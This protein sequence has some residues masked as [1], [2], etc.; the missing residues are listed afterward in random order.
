MDSRM[1]SQ[2][3]VV[4]VRAV[5]KR[6]ALG[7]VPVTALADVTVDIHAD[8]FTVISGPS[9]SGKSTL[10]NLMGCLDVPDSGS[11][12]VDGTDM[13]S[14]TDD[15]RSEFRARR[16]GFVFQSFN[17]IPVLTALEN[18]AYP[19]QLTGVSASQACRQAQEWLAAVGLQGKEKHLPSQLSGGQRQRVAIAR[20]LV[21][22]PSLVLADEPTA[23]L[24][25]A[26]GWD[27]VQLMRQMQRST[28]TSFIF[29]S[30]D[31]MLL[32]AADDRIHIVDGAIA[33]VERTTETVQ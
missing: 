10:L 21:N 11:V 7:K 29:S 24:D 31:P 27:I 12:C 3:P 17:L 13:A 19:L 33:G 9:G 14:L 1:Q 8:R 22:E 20:A 18:V 25:R 16:L 4:Q 23:N 15:Q 5:A 30:H 32:E 26:T 2:D 28:G 6:Y